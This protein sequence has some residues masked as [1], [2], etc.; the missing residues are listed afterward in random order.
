MF[1]FCKYK[2]Q[3]KGLFFFVCVGGG[4]CN[5]PSFTLFSTP[6]SLYYI[7]TYVL[8]LFSL[9]S[10]SFLYEKETKRQR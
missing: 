3:K 4:D 1:V 7:Y 2:I 5:R 8:P 9:I 10:R 6:V